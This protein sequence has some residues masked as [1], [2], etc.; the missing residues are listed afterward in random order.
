MGA[1]VKPFSRLPVALYGEARATELNG[2]WSLKPAAY[3]VTELPPLLITEK[4][5]AE[6]Y[7]QAGYVGGDFSTPFVDGQVKVERRMA[8][9]KGVDLHLGAGTWGGAQKGAARLDIGPT[10]SARFLIDEV[11]VRLTADY[12]VRVAGDAKPDSG[13]A[14]TLSSGF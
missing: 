13:L 6:A 2:S 1:G 8:T 14:I 9:V 10:A 11:P 4:F 3:A 5:G 12:R 7:A